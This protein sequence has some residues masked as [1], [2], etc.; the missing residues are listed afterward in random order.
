MELKGKIWKFGDNVDTDAI[1]PARYLNT[2]DP[3]ELAK[4]CMEDADA[5]FVKKISNLERFG[6]KWKKLGKFLQNFEDFSI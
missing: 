5:E 4:H 2:S 6:Q 1:I 3:A